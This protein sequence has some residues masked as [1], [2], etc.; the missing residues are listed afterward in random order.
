M[1]KVISLLIFLL[2][3]NFSWAKSSQYKE[4][5]FAGGCFWCL[6]SDFDYMRNHKELSHNG[7]IRVASGYDGGETKSPTYKLVSSG[8]TNYKESVRVV[9]DPNKI[10]YKELVEY[11][12]RR[13]NPTDSGGQFCDRGEQYQSAIYYLDPEQEKIAK[14]VTNNLKAEFKKN[15]KEVYTAILP[16]THFYKAEKY[17]QKYHDKNPKRYCYY[18]TGCGRDKTIDQ[19]WNG[20]NWQYSNVKP[21]DTPNNIIDCL[22]R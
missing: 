3:I 9:Y 18:R 15:D 7:I 14:E 6:E 2:F 17:H 1:R 10:S 22:S 20:I 11:F 8:T 13:I 21:F 16:S 5:I 19:V 4:A 12:F